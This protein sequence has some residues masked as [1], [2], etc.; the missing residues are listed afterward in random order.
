MNL[1]SEHFRDCPPLITSAG[2]LSLVL[3]FEYC[4]WHLAH[5]GFQKWTK[6]ACAES[7]EDSDPWPNLTTSGSSGFR[8]MTN[9]RVMISV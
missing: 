1:V 7:L 2:G 3:L 5:G 6:L 9:V 4:L 8:L